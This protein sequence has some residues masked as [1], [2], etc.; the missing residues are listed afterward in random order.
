M[1]TEHYS[2]IENKL[3]LTKP[4]AKEIDALVYLDTQSAELGRIPLPLSKF[5]GRSSTQRILF[6]LA[7]SGFRC[8]AVLDTGKSRDIVPT[9]KSQVKELNMEYMGVC[10][11]NAKSIDEAAL[12]W[13]SQVVV[14]QANLVFDERLM[15]K[16]VEHGAPARM[17]ASS[18]QALG[19]AR[20]NTEGVELLRVDQDLSIQLESLPH[21]SDLSIDS[22]AEYVPGMRRSFS[23]YWQ[24]LDQE[25]DLNK[26]ASKVMDSVQKGVLDFPARYLHPIPENFL[27]KLAA[28]TAITPNQITILSAVLAFIGTYWFSTQAYLPAL[29]IAIVAGILDG[30]DGKLARVKLLSSPFGDRLDHTLDVTFEFSWY[31]AIG[32][33][34]YQSTGNWSLFIYGFVLIGIMLTARALSGVYLLQTGHQIHDHTAFDRLVRL[35]AGRRNIFVFVLLLGYLSGNFLASFYVV[36]FWA[37]LTVVIYALRNVVV[38]AR[39]LLPA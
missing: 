10:Y 7:R 32:W 27:T 36:I 25:P 19:L 18:G 11:V 16:L 4:V 26:A 39:K 35:F 23:P 5:L 17:T 30:V 6:Q 15:D 24:V 1:D 22:I 33:G 3:W 28:K 34:L 37:V 20:L 38:F 8:C 2:P 21:L 31:V 9:L 14:V 13:S 12:T 29:L